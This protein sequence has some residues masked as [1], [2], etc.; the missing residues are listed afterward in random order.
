MRLKKRRELTLPA[1]DMYSCKL[2]PE[3]VCDKIYL[4]NNNIFHVKNGKV[5]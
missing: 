1:E 5:P 4:K 3:V 2:Y